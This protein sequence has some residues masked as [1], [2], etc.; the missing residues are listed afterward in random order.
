MKDTTDELKKQA[1]QAGV[2]F[3]KWADALWNR[4]GDTRHKIEENIRERPFVSSLALFTAGII[5]AR[6]VAR[7][8]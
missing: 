6:I 7:R 1:Y 2:T 4:A 5:T 3:R 8:G